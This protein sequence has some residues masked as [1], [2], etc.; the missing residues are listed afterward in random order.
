MR[1]FTLGLPGKLD[2]APDLRTGKGGE[3]FLNLFNALAK[4]VVLNDGVRENAGAAHNRPPR[5]FAGDAL[6][7]FAAGPVDIAIGDHC[8]VLPCLTFRGF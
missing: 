1:L 5:H 8:G 3:T 2:Q 6:N 4:F 7:E